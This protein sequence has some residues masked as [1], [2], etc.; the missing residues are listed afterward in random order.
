MRKPGWVYILAGRTGTLYTGVTS[1]L[2][3]RV[4]EHRGKI[5]PGFAAKYDCNRLVF[6]EGSGDIGRSIYREKQIKG[7]T[8]A[9]KDRADRRDE[10]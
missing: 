4:L 2:Y 10:S 1:N 8:R 5:Y 9:K 3:R 7:W 6:Y